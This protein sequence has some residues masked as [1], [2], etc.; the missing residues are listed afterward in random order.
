M[1]RKTWHVEFD[2]GFCFVEAKDDK[3]AEKRAAEEFGM[4]R[5]PYHATPARR[6]DLDRFKEGNG[7]VLE[8]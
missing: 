1:P 5:G 7:E 2:N 6:E 8:A 4:H 3:S